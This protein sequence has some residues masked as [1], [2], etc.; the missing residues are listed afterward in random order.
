MLLDIVDVLRCPARHEETWLVA[1]AERWSGRHVVAGKLG[2]P[3]CRAE[4]PIRDGVADFAPGGRATRAPSDVVAAR[5]DERPPGEAPALRLA[6]QLGLI[7][8]GGV[9]LLTGIYGRHADALA[10]TV[11]S[12]LIVLNSAS[13]VQA[14]ASE[15]RLADALPFAS[16]SV[17]AIAF[18]PAALPAALLDSAVRLLRAEG[19][20]VAPVGLAVPPGVRELARDEAEWVAASTAPPSAPVPLA[21]RGR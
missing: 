18:D 16:A 20:L 4:Y 14:A 12:R 1:S 15:I 21:R 11:E 10:D 6:A 2:C 9:V 17:R 8:P 13:R 19:R 5:P 7:D 3:V